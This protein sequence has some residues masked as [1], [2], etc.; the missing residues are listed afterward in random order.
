MTLTIQSVIDLLLAQVPE[1]PFK[2]TVDTVKA[3]DPTSRCA[4]S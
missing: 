4:A 1:A 3:G 2:G